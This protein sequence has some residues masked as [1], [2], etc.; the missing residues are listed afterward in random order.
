MTFIIAI[1]NGNT[2]DYYGG[3]TYVFQGGYYPAI[4]NR[5]DAKRYKS[6][7]IAERSAVA[8][9]RKCEGQYTVEEV[10]A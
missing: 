9:Q 6:R 2:G 10:E 7:K 4:T 8:A 1:H 5:R 3:S